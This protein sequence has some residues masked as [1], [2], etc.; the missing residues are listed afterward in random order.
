M[1]GKPI[2]QAERLQHFLRQQSLVRRNRDD[3]RDGQVSRARRGGLPEGHASTNQAK[4]G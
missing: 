4:T 2:L 3:A 1:P